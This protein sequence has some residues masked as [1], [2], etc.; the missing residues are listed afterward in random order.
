VFAPGRP[1]PLIVGTPGPRGTGRA[2][3]GGY[4]VSGRRG[5][6]SGAAYADWLIGGFR[7]PGDDGHPDRLLVAV[8][9]EDEVEIID[10][11]RVAGLQGS[12]SV[13]FRADEVFVPREMTFE[14]AAS[15]CR[16]GALFRQEAHVFLSNKVPPLCVGIARRAL[17]EMT[18]LAGRTARFP[19]GPT[20]AERAVFHKELGR[21]ETRIRAARLVHRAARSSATSAMC[22]PPASTSASR[23]RTTSARAATGSAGSPPQRAKRQ[24]RYRETLQQQASVPPDA[25]EGA[26]RWPTPC[27]SLSVM[28]TVNI[29]LS[30][31]TTLT[32]DLSDL[33]LRK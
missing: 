21:A 27:N 32:P 20:L 31:V 6:A 19:G 18:D 5:F 28:T 17:D 24:R 7:V 3:A 22:W 25:I 29:S 23:K 2:A 10:N 13:D 9:P 30:A 12:G 16:G 26:R 4:V 15:A 14:R 33:S 8:M 11:W 1:L